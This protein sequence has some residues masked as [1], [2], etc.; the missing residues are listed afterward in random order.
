MALKPA[1]LLSLFAALMLQACGNGIGPQ[2][3]APLPALSARASVSEARAASGQVRKALYITSSSPYF[4]DQ[5]DLPLHRGQRPSLH[6]I[7]VN[8][9]FPV[10]VDDRNVYVGSFDDGTV[11][12]YP[13]PLPSKPRIF[14]PG[15]G[16][17]SGLAIDGDYLY[18]AGGNGRFAEVL[19]YRLPLIGGEPP[20]GEIDGQ[21][22]DLLELAARNGT[23]Y[24]SSCAT[25]NIS[26]YRLPL[27]ASNTPRYTIPT[28]GSEYGISVAVDRRSRNLYAGFTLDDEVY[29]YRLPYHNGEQPTVL[30]VLSKSGRHVTSVAAGEGRLFVTAGGILAY[31]LPVEAGA[32]PAVSVRFGGNAAGIAV[33][34]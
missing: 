32:S 7:G 21:S 5:F 34:P 1:G 2:S 24:V 16:D 15:I 28:Q 26:A 19:Q 33:S 3:R 25:G 13:L 20:S 31:R 22:N 17:L 23:L 14:S 11:F 10:A 12:T 27:G 29:D 30:Q 9:P 18:V 4:F 8:E 6:E